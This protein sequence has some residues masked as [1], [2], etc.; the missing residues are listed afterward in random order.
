MVAQHRAVMVVQSEEALSG[1]DIVTLCS[2]C[3]ICV[4]LAGDSTGFDGLAGLGLD[5]GLV[6][7][8]GKSCEG[9]SCCG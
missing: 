2:S 1:W 3:H 4:G 9:Q 7:V 6:L 8:K 5:L